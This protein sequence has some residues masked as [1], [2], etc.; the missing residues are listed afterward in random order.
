MAENS[1]ET[2]ALGN[3]L[4]LNGPFTTLGRLV[5]VGPYGIHKGSDFD[6]LSKD[7]HLFDPSSTYHRTCLA[8]YNEVTTSM[9]HRE[10]LGNVATLQIRQA[11]PPN[12][13]TDH[14][15]QLRKRDRTGETSEG[16]GGL[17]LNL[18]A[19]FTGNMELI[20]TCLSSHAART[21]SPGLVKTFY[22]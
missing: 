22:F 8:V 21:L 2:G 13:N 10:E 15:S 9:C 4:S 5:E 19:R 17:W 14:T 16:D 3:D 20:F 6:S 1:G 18:V 7:G 12:S 11:G